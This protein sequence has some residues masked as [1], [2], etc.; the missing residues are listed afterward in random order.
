MVFRMLVGA[1]Y[2]ISKK[3]NFLYS[4]Y[5]IQAWPLPTPHSLNHSCLGDLFDVPLAEEN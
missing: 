3:L 2:K 5:W 1:A 4:F